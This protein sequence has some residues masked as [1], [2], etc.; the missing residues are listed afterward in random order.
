MKFTEVS[1]E[2]YELYRHM[3]DQ[4]HCPQTFVDNAFTFKSVKLKVDDEENPT[5]A[6][7]DFN[8]AIILVGSPDSLTDEEFLE[9]IPEGLTII[10]DKETWLPRLL[11]HFKGKLMERR[12][13]KMSHKHLSLEKL[14]N[15]KRPLPDGYSLERIDKETAENLPEI[16]QVHIPVFFGSVD[17]FLEKTVSFCVKHGNN[18]ISLASATLPHTNLLEVQVATVDKPEYRRKGFGTAVSIA[19]VEYCLE[20][21]IEPH[22]EAANDTSVEM[23]LKLGYTDPKDVYQYYWRNE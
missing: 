7:L 8:Y 21:N 16:L 11:R 2:K 6:Y 3:F 18:P 22:W 10:A 9:L 13:T 15:L 1:I 5:I 4:E 12:R 19:L 14:E 23:A 17:N 20:N